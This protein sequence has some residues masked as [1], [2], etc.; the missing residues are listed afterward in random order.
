MNEILSAGA[1]RG[2]HGLLHRLAARGERS[3][4]ILDDDRIEE[5]NL[6]TLR[7]SRESIGWAKAEAL[8]FDLA[9]EY[10]ALVRWADSKFSP[11]L[12]ERALHLPTWCSA[13]GSSWHSLTTWPLN[14]R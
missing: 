8:A 7:R 1:G 12:V 14:W 10:G 4:A 9:A 6:L 3:F 5:A 13:R 2:G 11:A